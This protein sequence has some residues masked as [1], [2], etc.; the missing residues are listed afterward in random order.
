[1]KK[2]VAQRFGETPVGYGECGRLFGV[3]HQQLDKWVLQGCPREA[4]GTF[5][6][7]QVADWLKARA[8]LKEELAKVKLRKEKE[9][10]K[11]IKTSTAELR[12]RME[13]KSGELHD[14][15]ACDLSFAQAFTACWTEF[16]LIPEPGQAAFPAIPGLK[17]KLTELVNQAAAQIQKIAHAEITRT[18][19]V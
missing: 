3:A 7:K 17:E 16:Q 14:G 1:M 8:K 2:H 12:Q 11:R 10:A 9:S 4:D 18:N 15:Q 19:S 6:P 13:I 5:I